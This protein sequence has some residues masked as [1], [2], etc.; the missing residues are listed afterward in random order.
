MDRET[1]RTVAQQILA[2]L[3]IFL[4]L[5]LFITILAIINPEMTAL[6]IGGAF[7]ILF[8]MFLIPVAIFGRRGFTAIVITILVL[9]FLGWFVKR[10]EKEKKDEEWKRRM[11]Y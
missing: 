7:L 11:M 5:I 4:T 10:R 9:L 8:L 3:I 6:A 1:A 2:G